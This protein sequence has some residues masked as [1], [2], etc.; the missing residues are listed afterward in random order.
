MVPR[1]ESE[2]LL[3]SIKTVRILTGAFISLFIVVGYSRDEVLGRN[4]RFL[5]GPGTSLEV[6]KQVGTRFNIKIYI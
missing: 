5:N 6:L 3:F 2:S 4:C 1:N